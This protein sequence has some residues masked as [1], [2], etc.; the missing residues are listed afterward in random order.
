MKELERKLLSELMK[1]SRRSDRE[2]AKAIGVSQP[3]TTRLRTK[4]EKEGYIKEYTI[5]PNFSKIGYTIMALNFVK[6]DPK[7]TKNGIEGFRNAHP[8]TIGK[9]PFGVVLIQRGMGLGYDTVIVSFHQD[10]SSY[11]N[12]RNYVKHAMG[13][14]ITEM[15]V[16]LINLDEEKNTLPP[17]FL[18]LSREMLKSKSKTKE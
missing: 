2:L 11:D 14:S 10:Y 18:F 1:N 16:F 6:L 8:E 4:L 5:I 13:E 12:F 7:L 15:N 17:T 3:T 9:D